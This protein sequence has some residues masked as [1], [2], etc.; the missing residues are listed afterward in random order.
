[1]EMKKTRNIFAAL[2]YF[3]TGGL[4]FI[5]CL[6]ALVIGRAFERFCA[7][8]SIIYYTLAF[9]LTLIV[10]GLT[11]FLAWGNTGALIAVIPTLGLLFAIPGYFS[12]K[13]HQNIPVYLPLI[14]KPIARL[15]G[16]TEGKDEVK[17]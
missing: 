3:Q 2:T 7:V 15:V 17:K 11:V 10:F 9:F 14:G 12:Y 16:Y 6:F 1:M 8:Q 4:H 5:V 13:A